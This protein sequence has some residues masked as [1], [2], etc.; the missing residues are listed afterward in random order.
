MDAVHKTRQ[1]G[2]QDVFYAQ[3]LDAFSLAFWG[4]FQAYLNSL[5]DWK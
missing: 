1:V 3:K 5:V 2:K 4:L